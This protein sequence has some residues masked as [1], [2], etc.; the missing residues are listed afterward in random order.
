MGG[1]GIPPEVFVVTAE[2]YELPFAT[3]SN[4][5][6]E[7]ADYIAIAAAVGWITVQRKDLSFGRRW[8]ITLDGLNA[9]RNKEHYRHA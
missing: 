2:A 3:K 4:F 7:Y 6:R 5:A 8:L 1:H 9:L